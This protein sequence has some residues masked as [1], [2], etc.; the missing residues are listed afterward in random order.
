MRWNLLMWFWFVLPLW[1]EMLSIS[2]WFFCYLDYFESL[3]FWEFTI[4]SSLC[5]LVIKPLLDI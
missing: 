4:L 5:I 2:S 1:S 3:I